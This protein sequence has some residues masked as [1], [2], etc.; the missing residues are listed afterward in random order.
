[1]LRQ[2]SLV[3][4][5]ETDLQR[6]AREH[7]AEISVLDCRSHG[8]DEMVFLLDISS[9]REDAE[10]VIKEL[11]SQGVFKKVNVGHSAHASRAVCT[12]ERNTPDL[13]RA[14]L[15][16]GAFCLDCPYSRTGNDERWRLLITDS[17]QL[18]LI[19]RRLERRG[20]K[21]TIGELSEPRGREQLTPRQRQVFAQ[22]I[23]LGF[24]EFPRRISLTELSKTLGVKPSTLSQL[25][26]AA[27]R[28]VIS[29]YASE[30]KIGDSCRPNAR[31]PLS[32]N[33]LVL[34]QKA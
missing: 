11:K 4:K 24:F 5:G 25:L 22:A 31:L 1:M 8:A 27:E 19:L 18:Q 33:N 26:R 6:F 16:S 17:S 34:T 9:A 2:V 7:D 13:C 14:V 15:G 32:T 12:A 3:L 30:M 20:I 21:A 10:A 29:S 23:C 28:K